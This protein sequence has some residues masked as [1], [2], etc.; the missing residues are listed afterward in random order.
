MIEATQKL[1]TVEFAPIGIWKLNLNLEVVEANQAAGNLLGVT[2]DELIGK[3]ILDLVPSLP[4]QLF[5][6]ALRSGDSVSRKQIRIDELEKQGSGQRYWEMSLGPLKAGREAVSGLVLST[7]EVTERELLRQQREDFI[8]ALSHNLKSPLVGADMILNSLLREGQGPLT[9]QQTE[10]LALLKSSNLHV[11]EMVQELVEVYRFETA[12]AKLT[13]E[14]IKLEDLIST[15]LRTFEHNAN[16]VGVTLQ[17]AVEQDAIVHGDRRALR[18]MLG[19]LI[20]NGIKFTPRDGKITVVAGVLDGSMLIKVSDTGCGIDLPDPEILFQ[21]F[22]Q[23][24]PGKSYSAVT[25][26]GLYLC[27]QIINAHGG[28]IKAES[29][30][31]VGTTFSV[32][33]PITA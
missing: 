28:T 12:S 5:L 2:S 22:W 6:E 29:I 32:R 27:R 3:R 18:M 7:V 19:N 26:L 24:Q 16:L 31:D 14:K 33:L 23:G 25:G 8:A 1:K 4:M 20:D 17:Y 15:S 30:K 10:S 11:L 13:F 21:R 9:P